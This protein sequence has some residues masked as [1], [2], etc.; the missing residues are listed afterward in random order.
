VDWAQNGCCPTLARR[1][2]RSADAFDVTGL[3]RLAEELVA[4]AG[5]DRDG[6]RQRPMRRGTGGLMMTQPRGDILIV[7]DEPENVRL[8]GS[9]LA[10]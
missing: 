2:R 5:S 7:D 8:L 4:S 6:L 9:L 3:R 1:V 10:G